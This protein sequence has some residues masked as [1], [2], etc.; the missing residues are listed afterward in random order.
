MPEHTDQHSSKGITRTSSSIPWSDIVFPTR[1]ELPPEMEGFQLCESIG[2]GS[3]GTVFR[4]IQTKEFAVKVVSWH[5]NNLRE[6]AKR[7]YDVAR[8][9]A[10]C[11]KTIHVIAYYEHDCNS[12]MAGTAVRNTIIPPSSGSSM[13]TL[14]YMST[15]ASTAPPATNGTM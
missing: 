2:S 11:E 8:L 1:P 3:T 10:D 13:R 6:I 4:S 12:F 7:E 15:S 14:R 9:F 5:P